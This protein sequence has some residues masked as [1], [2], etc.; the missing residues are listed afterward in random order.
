MT[1]SRFTAVLLATA[2]AAGPVAA[3]TAVALTEDGRI[4]T[5][6]LKTLAAG[7]P[8]A[9]TGTNG[10]LLGFDVRPADG[11]L[12]G[13]VADGAIVTLDPATGRATVVARLDTTPPAGPSVTVDFNPVAD[14]L[15]VI[16]TDGTNLRVD[17]DAG[18][19]TRDGA[20]RFA[21]GDPNRG[22][23]PRVVAG[24]YTNA[25]RGAK[26]TT[27]YDV[28]ATL[29]ALVRQVPPNDGILNAVGLLGDAGTPSA[30]DILTDP[31]GG[32]T[33]F[34]MAGRILHRVD[35]ATGRA[36]PVGEVKGLTGTVRDIAVLPAGP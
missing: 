8:V 5:L 14:R 3:Q 19:T 4:A 9:V 11:R 24:A 16:G 36:T 31:A 17:V 6:D 20:L 12:Y 21:D 1:R 13:V 29:G 7:T 18:K 35:L 32:D 10:P 33:A 30:L 15:R 25:T 26:E 34:L 28:D 2:F 27:L 22:R 23:T